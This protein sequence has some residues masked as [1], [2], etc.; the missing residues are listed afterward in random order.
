MHDLRLAIRALR[1][2]PVV[3]VV[4][5][6]SLALGI[7]ANTAIFSLIDSLML[8]ALPVSQPDRLALLTDATSPASAQS[9]TNPIWEQIRQRSHLV[10]GALAWSGSRFNL[11]AG[12]ET[13]FVDGIWVSGAFFDTL[14]VPAMLGRTL[15]DADDR[16]GGGADG[17]VIVISY[18]FWQ[19]YF[20]GAADAIGRTLTLDR[21]PFT[22]VG[23]TPPGFFGTDIGRSYDVAVPL[24]DEPLIRG[25]DSG[26]DRRSMWWLSVMVR[27][28]PGQSID[29]ATAALR[30]V[31]PQIRDA[32]I[33]DN[34]RPQDVSSYLKDPFTLFSASTGSSFLRERFHK[35]LMTIMIVVALVLLIACAN[36]ANLLLARATARRHELSVRVA[37][38]A[39]RWRL[40]RQLMTK[41]AAVR[42]RRRSRHADRVVGEPAA[43]RSALDID[44]HRLS[45]SLARLARA[46]LHDR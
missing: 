14:G 43:G 25:R 4:A 20:N 29:T 3:S 31:Q 28:K 15:T 33:P 21:V 36:I 12:G 18:S 24:G 26:L 22:V 42:R 5:V 16:R 46:R 40:A 27:M 39:S 23:V 19:Q 10:D 44:Q 8:R 35:P 34:W 32:T 6:L 45:R 7:G 37:L 41:P 13:R 2:T 38:G 9:W 11:A 30:G 17:P 1:A